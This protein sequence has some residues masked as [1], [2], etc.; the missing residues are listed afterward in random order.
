[1]SKIVTFASLCSDVNPIIMN[2]FYRVTT[3]RLPTAVDLFILCSAERIL[4]A[5]LNLPLRHLLLNTPLRA[6][7]MW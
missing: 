6:T 2:A 4:K 1:M 3:F 7:T 5:P